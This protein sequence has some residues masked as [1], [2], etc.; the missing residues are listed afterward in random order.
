MCLLKD[1][2]RLHMLWEWPPDEL[3]LAEFLSCPQW[4][5]ISCCKTSHVAT[6]VRLNLE[7]WADL[8][9]PWAPRSRSLNYNL[10]HG[11]MILF[12]TWYCGLLMGLYFMGLEED[13]QPWSTSHVLCKIRQCYSPESP[14]LNI[15]GSFSAWVY[16]IPCLLWYTLLDL[17]SF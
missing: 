4:S 3:K 9:C 7:L 2:S 5:M 6:P 16:H 8:S 1:H 11:G 13:L 17:A 15:Q 10:L 14:D 12:I